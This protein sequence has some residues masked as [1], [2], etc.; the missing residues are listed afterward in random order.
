MQKPSWVCHSCRAGGLLPILS[1]GETPLA[2]RL[3]DAEELQRPEPRHP[4][5]LA[6]CRRCTLL[7]ITE[8]ISPEQLFRDYVYFS[9]YSDTAVAQAQRLSAQLISDRRLGKES[10]VVEVA[11]N[12][13]YLLRHY[14]QAGIPVQG[15]EPAVNVAEVAHRD[16]GIPTWPAFFDPSLARQIRQARGA[17]DVV[18]AHNVLAHVAD[19]NGFVAGLRHLLKPSGILVI[20][21]PY[22]RDL[23]ESVQFDT[24]YHE[25][26]CYFSLTA[27]DHLARRNGLVVTDVERIAIHGGSLRLV[28][29]RQ[30]T[31]GTRVAELLEEEANWG[32][33]SSRAYHLFGAR[34]ES[35]RHD[36]CTMLQRLKSQGMRIAAY[37]ASAKGS[38]LLNYCGIG[39]P[40][41]DFVVDRNPVKQQRYT[42]GTRLKIYDPSKLLS[43]QPDYVLLLTWNF[44]DEILEQQA[45]YRRRGGRF[46]IPVP[47]IRVA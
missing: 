32:I 15:V 42:P 43:E 21:V 25:H 47:R 17:A 36:L 20:E 37:G 28:L 1:L 8:A 19:L 16:H 31:T 13:G 26:R 45:D 2:N 11:S 27:L 33:V 24:I 10:L 23:I 6:M 44:A 41:I 39:R 3:L 29:G 40:T 46:I 35:L 38:T 5:N 34:V 4:L 30:G 9:S 7:Q 18:H 12:D 22:V 14:R